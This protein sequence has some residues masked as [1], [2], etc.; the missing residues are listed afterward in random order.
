VRASFQTLRGRNGFLL[1]LCFFGPSFGNKKTHKMVFIHKIIKRIFLKT[2]CVNKPLPPPSSIGSGSERT[3][4][5]AKK[6]GNPVI[7]SIRGWDID[8]RLGGGRE[9]ER[10]TPC[11][12]RERGTCKAAPRASPAFSRMASAPKCRSLRRSEPKT[13]PATHSCFG[14]SLDTSPGDGLRKKAG[15]NFL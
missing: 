5:G 8:Y 11:A 12:T 7:A 9:R 6:G 14:V 1:L 4:I 3:K 2:F 15:D 13:P 10:G